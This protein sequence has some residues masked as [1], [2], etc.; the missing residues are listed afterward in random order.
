VPL[1]GRG[2]QRSS[3]KV[4]KYV[5]LPG[6][7]FGLSACHLPSRPSLPVLLFLHALPLAGARMCRPVGCHSVCVLAA[8]PALTRQRSILIWRRHSS[9]LV[10]CHIW[11]YA[12]MYMLLVCLLCMP[13]A[14]SDQMRSAV[15]NCMRHP[16]NRRRTQAV[17][18]VLPYACSLQS[19][20]VSTVNKQPCMQASRK[21]ESPNFPHARLHMQAQLT[22]P[23]VLQHCTCALNTIG[24]VG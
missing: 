7:R 3:S 23:T 22:P 4:C 2:L 15:A 9:A 1:P 24:E 11:R 13:L 10:C 6:R 18:R 17:C 12:S 8:L 21:A 5:A 20:R 19:L 14:C 16:L